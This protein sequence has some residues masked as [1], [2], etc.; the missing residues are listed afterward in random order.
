MTIR[1]TMCRAVQDA[2]GFEYLCMNAAGERR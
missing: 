1:V 2:A